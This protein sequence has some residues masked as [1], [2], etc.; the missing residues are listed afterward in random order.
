M[1]DVPGAVDLVES[2][3]RGERSKAG[4]TTEAAML[5]GQRT[6]AA[7][8]MGIVSSAKRELI[9]A[10]DAQGQLLACCG[11]EERGRGVARF[12][13]FAV[14]PP[15]QGGGVGKLL[16]AEAERVARDVWA[17]HTLEMTVI[18]QRDDLIAWYLRRGYAL[19]GETRPFPY[20]D[21][22]FGLPLR[23]DLRFVMLAKPLARPLA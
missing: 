12:G 4:W 10:I 23:D 6:D 15:L 22:R 5:E 17:C 9:V 1:D 8:L 20:G 3:Y 21:E 16:L 18:A 2:A 13:P 11:L 14:R 7:E 19:T